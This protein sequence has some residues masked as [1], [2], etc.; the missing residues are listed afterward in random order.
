MNQWHPEREHCGISRLKIELPIIIS[1]GKSLK[2]IELGSL[3]GLVHDQE[4]VSSRG[5]ER[6]PH[7]HAWIVQALH[8]F[9]SGDVHML[10]LSSIRLVLMNQG[11][12]YK[13]VL[14]MLGTAMVL[15][16]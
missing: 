5:M 13:Q 8:S 2:F 14:S 11:V 7:V 6:R 12:S 3:D 4:F 15:E 1:I 9:L 16:M 10:F